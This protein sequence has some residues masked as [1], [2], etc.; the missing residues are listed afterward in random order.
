MSDQRIGRIEFGP[1]GSFRRQESPAV[2][3]PKPVPATPFAC[4]C[5]PDVGHRDIL[6]CLRWGRAEI[7]RLTARL[8]K[9]EAQAWIDPFDTWETCRHSDETE[10]PTIWFSGKYRCSRC[11]AMWARDMRDAFAA[12]QPEGDAGEH[13]TRS[14]GD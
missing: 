14:K 1:G 13:D 3:L 9:A 12:A 11:I 8:A 7:A 2:M 4:D 10:S 5:G 6:D